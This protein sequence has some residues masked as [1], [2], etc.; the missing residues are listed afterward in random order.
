MSDKRKLILECAEALLVSEGDCAFSMQTIADSV[1]I[2]KGAIYLHFRSKEDLLLAV[3]QSQTNNLLEKITTVLKNATLTPDEKLRQQIRFQHEDLQQYQAM[4]NLLLQEES[5]SLNHSLLM[6]YQEFRLTWL[7][8]QVGFLREKYGDQIQRWE[9]DLAMTLDGIIANYLSLSVVEGID[10]DTEKLVNW[11]VSCLDSICTQLPKQGLPPVLTERDLPSLKE[12]EAKKQQLQQQ[13]VQQA[14]SQLKNK[15]Q[16]LKLSEPKR[17]IVEHTLTLLE[18]QLQNNNPDTILL[19]ALIA[20]L[21][22]YRGLNN[23]RQ[24]LAERLDVE[25]V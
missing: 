11:V 14:L 6:F 1:G 15:A 22:D 24:L 13:Q 3:F 7:T 8:L 19:R 12:I 2:S 9:T 25:V 21:R 20:G 18:N 16:K 4:F 10:F 5:L 17:K 23:E